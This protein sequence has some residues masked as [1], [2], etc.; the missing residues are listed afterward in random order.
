MVD[1]VDRDTYY[2][3]THAKEF[4]KNDSDFRPVYIVNTAAAKLPFSLII[5]ASGWGPFKSLVLRH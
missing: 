5:D 3:Q 2:L 1:L 4:Q